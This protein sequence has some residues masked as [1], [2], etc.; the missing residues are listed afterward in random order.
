MNEREKQEKQVKNI[1]DRE[2]L[3]KI[4]CFLRS[5]IEPVVFYYHLSFKTFPSWLNIDV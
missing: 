2:I 1:R 3:H 5:F 4:S